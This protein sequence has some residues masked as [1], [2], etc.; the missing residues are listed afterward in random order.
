[1]YLNR[2]LLS[3]EKYKRLYESEHV[4][5]LTYRD[6]ERMV[7][8]FEHGMKFLNLKK[9]VNDLKLE[10]EKEKKVLLEKE[11][12]KE[13]IVQ[14][15]KELSKEKKEKPKER[16]TCRVK[17]SKKRRIDVGSNNYDTQRNL[18]EARLK[19]LDATKLKPNVN[20]EEVSKE[21]YSSY[22]VEAPIKVSEESK[23]TWFK[24]KP[25]SSSR[26]V[27]S[28]ETDGFNAFKKNP[29]V[30]KRRMTRF[31]YNVQDDAARKIVRSRSPSAVLRQYN[32]EYT[33]NSESL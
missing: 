6:L 23:A 26:I 19:E 27:D 18:S 12:E 15:D 16:K 24:R 10:K 29:K 21:T 33:N 28:F 1:M 22:A 3:K 5:D 20:V 32:E 25:E 31:K 8:L 30:P 4:D 13:K 7:Y 9:L 11:L 14:K 2:L 17:K